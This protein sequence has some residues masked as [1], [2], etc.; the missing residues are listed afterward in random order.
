MTIQ[1]LRIQKRLSAVE[2]SKKAGV[3]PQTYK[4]LEDGKNLPKVQ[5]IR[6]VAK[7]LGEEIWDLTEFR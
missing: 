4:A 5:T 7:V 1:E 3:A 2:V 6:K